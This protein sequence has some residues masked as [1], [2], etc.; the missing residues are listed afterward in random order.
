MKPLI[1]KSEFK[2]MQDVLLARNSRHGKFLQDILMN[3]EQVNSLGETVVRLNSLV[4]LWHELLKKQ[5]KFEVVLPGNA[6]LKKRKL[7]VFS[8]ICLAI[9]GRKEG[10]FVE[11]NRA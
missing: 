10:D 2:K 9:L 8:P 4:E 5:V 6:D 1:L 11:T 3:Y 7:S